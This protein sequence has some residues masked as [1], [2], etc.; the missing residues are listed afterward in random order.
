MPANK[1]STNMGRNTDEGALANDN[2]RRL[3]FKFLF[4]FLILLSFYI[5]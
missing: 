2:D 5:Y 3:G 1:Q 4:F